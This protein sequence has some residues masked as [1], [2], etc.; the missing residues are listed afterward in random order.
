MA[1]KEDYLIRYKISIFTRDPREGPP[2]TPPRVVRWKVGE[3]EMR[4]LCQE[5]WGV[6][7]MQHS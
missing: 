1:N 4:S 2:P 5:R 3:L 6:V 7:L